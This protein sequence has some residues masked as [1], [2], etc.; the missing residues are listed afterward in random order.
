MP[1]SLLLKPQIEY[2]IS[3]FPMEFQ[4]F[5]IIWEIKIHNRKIEIKPVNP[6]KS[7]ENPDIEKMQANLF[8]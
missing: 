6:Q 5:L 4:N 2:F 7:W 1:T 8:Y 3:K